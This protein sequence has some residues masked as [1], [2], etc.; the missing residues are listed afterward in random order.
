LLKV[1]PGLEKAREFPNAIA[2]AHGFAP[3][4]MNE[5]N[6]HWQVERLAGLG[7]ALEFLAEL[8][9]RL[10]DVLTSS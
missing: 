5:A 6:N 2:R 1:K 7:F 3:R 10:L 8:L 4:A 9:S